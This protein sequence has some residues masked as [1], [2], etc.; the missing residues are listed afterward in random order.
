VYRKRRPFLA[1]TGAENLETWKA[2]RKPFLVGKEGVSMSLAGVQ[3]KLA[4]AV[5]QIRRINARK[6]APNG[7]LSAFGG[8]TVGGF[9][10]SLDEPLRFNGS[11]GGRGRG[12]SLQP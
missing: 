6:S 10:V 3:T 4:V 12:L 9:S 11:V 8:D 7:L 1:T 5:D 2:D